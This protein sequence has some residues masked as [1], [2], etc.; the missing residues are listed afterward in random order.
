MRPFRTEMALT[1]NPRARR[2]DGYLGRAEAAGGARER[3]PP[4][5]VAAY[6]AARLRQRL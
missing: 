2:V 1:A 6:G 5:A 4:Q 3:H